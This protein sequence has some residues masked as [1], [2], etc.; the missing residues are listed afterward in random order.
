MTAIA[1][2]INN[3]V[4]EQCYYD[5]LLMHLITKYHGPRGV[6]KR[7]S[8]ENEWCNSFTSFKSIIQELQVCIRFGLY[9]IV[10]PTLC[11][12]ILLHQVIYFHL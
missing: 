9:K 2:Q 1:D 12:M 3:L 6:L 8:E 11:R 5:V 10:F 4:S 7:L